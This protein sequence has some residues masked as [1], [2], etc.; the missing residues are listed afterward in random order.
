MPEPYASMFP[1]GGLELPANVAVPAGG[2]PANRRLG[3]AAQL[4]E[5]I[6]MDDW[7]RVWAAHLGL[8]R[9]AD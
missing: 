8:V 1:P 9:L 5:G 2:E 6:S 4:A 7:R 3:I